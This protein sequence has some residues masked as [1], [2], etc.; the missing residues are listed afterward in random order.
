MHFKVIFIEIDF[1]SIFLKIFL[2][3]VSIF[4]NSYV[5]EGVGNNK[6][7]LRNIRKF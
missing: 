1:I 2:G 4:I 3:Y 6:I 5:L 7:I